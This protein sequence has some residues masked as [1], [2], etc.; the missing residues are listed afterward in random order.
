MFRPQSHLPLPLPLPTIVHTLVIG[1]GFGVVPLGTRRSRPACLFD[2]A[3]IF[4]KDTRYATLAG[5]NFS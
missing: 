1:V 3:G 2:R 5:A 4:G